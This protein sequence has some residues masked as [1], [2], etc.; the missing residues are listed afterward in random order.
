[1]QVSALWRHPIKS[2]G[3]ESIT[4]TSLTAGQTMPGDRLW[5]VTHETT[6]PNAKNGDWASCH[7]FQIGA[8]NP[9]LAGLW[10][11]LSDGMDKITLSHQA[12]G[13]LSFNPDTP[14]DQARFLN[15][16]AP[17]CPES[18]SQ[19]TGILRATTRGMTD[20]DYPSVSIMTTASHNAVAQAMG[21]IL[22]PERWRGNIWLDGAAPWE[23]FDWIGHE[24]RIGTA[25]LRVEEPIGR[26]PHTTANPQTGA[27]DADTLGT[28]E[29]S[30]GHKNFGVYARV[31]ED[32]A[33][34]LG[35]EARLA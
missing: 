17:I 29:R 12:L 8:R 9:L 18:R 1:M 30:F 4:R 10:A 28:L 20:S 35:D 13:E 5:A 25:L 24:I 14:E 19:P 22:E 7:N 34:A 32:G 26:C 27:R 21:G 23:E 31:I 15:W 33:I 2:H 6:Q 3:R 16:I 11:R